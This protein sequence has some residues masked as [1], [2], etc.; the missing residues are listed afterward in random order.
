M[1][2][3]PPYETFTFLNYDLVAAQNMTLAA[4]V[5]EELVLLAGEM[6][7]QENIGPTSQLWSAFYSD[8]LRQ[9]YR[10]FFEEVLCFVRSCSFSSSLDLRCLSMVFQKV[11]SKKDHRR[12]R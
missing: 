2:V 1:T 4:E 5:R 10:M 11:P 9:K 8:L 7:Q 12:A 6:L 3:C